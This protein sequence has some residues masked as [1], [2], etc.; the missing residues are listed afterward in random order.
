[1]AAV[2]SLIATDTPTVGDHVKQGIPAVVEKERPP[3]LDDRFGVL[4]RD[5]IKPEY[6]EAVKA[7][8]ERLLKELEQEAER[9]G[10]EQQNAIP[11]VTW[12]D[13]VANGLCPPVMPNMI[14]EPCEG[15]RN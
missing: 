7:S 3:Q 8:W 5:I 14:S 12:S 11:E 10:A 9:L 6:E 4:K 1:M 2:S 13:V 15:N